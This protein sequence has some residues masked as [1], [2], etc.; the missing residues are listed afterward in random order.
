MGNFFQLADQRG[1]TPLAYVHRHHW[2]EFKTFLDSKMDEWWP[3]V[4]SNKKDDSVLNGSP[5]S[6]T[7]PDPP[8]ALNL[9]LASM[10]VSGKL[11][12]KEAEILTEEQNND[13]K[14]DESSEEDDD[15]D[16]EDDSDY[17]S[18]DSEYDSENDDYDM[19]D[20]EMEEMMAMISSAGG[21]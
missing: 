4:Q 10:V 19:S 12:P 20:G 7:I 17:D 16:I 6:W 13:M 11:S 2:E 8:D 15:D 3:I 21:L 1:S 5:N 9:T 14:E 18:D